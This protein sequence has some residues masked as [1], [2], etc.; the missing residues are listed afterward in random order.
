MAGG[1]LIHVLP[2]PAPPGTNRSA[3]R[4]AGDDVEGTSAELVERG[5]TVESPISDEGW[6]RPTH[7]RLT[8]GG[9]VGLYE[10]RHTTA[11]DL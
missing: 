9:R 2:L 3:R 7:I 11:F 10:A 8:G 1:E 6:G 5:V 4:R